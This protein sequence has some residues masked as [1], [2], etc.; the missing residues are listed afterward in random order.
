MEIPAPGQAFYQIILFLQQVRLFSDIN[1]IVATI[2]DKLLMGY[3]RLCNYLTYKVFARN[4]SLI[5]DLN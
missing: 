2:S 1:P 4:A 5:L 3:L